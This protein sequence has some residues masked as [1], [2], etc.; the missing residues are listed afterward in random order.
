MGTTFVIL[1]ALSILSILVVYIIE[2]LILKKKVS[3][4]N[5]FIPINISAIISFISSFILGIIFYKFQRLDQIYLIPLIASILFIL[6]SFIL[7]KTKSKFRNSIIA[8]ITTVL[9]TI[10]YISGNSPKFL[11]LINRLYA[12]VV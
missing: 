5:I 10:V 12:P 2:K 6:L 8:T 4:K 3:F 1:T 9:V 7:Y 11:F